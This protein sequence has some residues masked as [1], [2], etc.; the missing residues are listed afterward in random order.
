MLVSGAGVVIEHRWTDDCEPFWTG[1]SQAAREEGGSVFF[2]YKDIKIVVVVV[3]ENLQV[4][5]FAALCL[6][7]YYSDKILQN[8]TA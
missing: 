5:L 2:S 4:L 1:A 3:D 6:L 8:F 7:L